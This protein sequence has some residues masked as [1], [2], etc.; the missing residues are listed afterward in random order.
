M[1]YRKR[2][3]GVLLT[4]SITILQS[5]DTF[6]YEKPRVYLD[7]YPEMP[8]KGAKPENKFGTALF[9]VG[10]SETVSCGQN[11][12]IGISSLKKPDII[13]NVT[14]PS[15]VSIF[16]S[17]IKR[18]VSLGLFIAA[19]NRE[20]SGKCY[21]ELP[22]LFQGASP[23]LSGVLPIGQYGVWIGVLGGGSSASQGGIYI[24]VYEPSRRPRSSSKEP[25]KQ[26]IDKA[27]RKRG[28]PDSDHPYYEAPN[29]C[30]NSPD[31]NWFSSG[32]GFKPACDNHDRCYATIGKSKDTCDDNFKKDMDKICATGTP[33]AG[34]STAANLYY[35]AVI[36]YGTSAY[37]TAQEEAKKYQDKVEEFKKEWRQKMGR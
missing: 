4:A 33:V 18:N 29:G 28:F 10:G 9:P 5:H 3:V 2:I 22:L 34:C 11:G 7:V 24:N 32:T 36:E 15:R 25:T 17:N 37:S 19:K 26:D 8:Q 6:A 27:L 21:P 35:G 1:D 14:K 23:T 16:L 13:L 12:T 31:S 30:S 20:S